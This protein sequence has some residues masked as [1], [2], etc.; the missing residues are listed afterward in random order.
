MIASLKSFC[1]VL[2]QHCS[3]SLPRVNKKINVTQSG[4]NWWKNVYSN[5]I[6]DFFAPFE[7][8][9]KGVWYNWNAF[10]FHPI[11]PFVLID[12]KC[13]RNNWA[14]KIDTNEIKLQLKH[15]AA[16]VDIIIIIINAG[17]IST[18]L[19]NLM[20][21]KLWRNRCWWEMCCAQP[22]GESKED[23]I[24]LES[25]NI[26]LLNAAMMWFMSSFSDLQMEK[27]HTRKVIWS[28]FPS[29]SKEERVGKTC[30]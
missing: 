13:D 7:V 17:R 26:F 16:C 21:K 4:A 20:K 2:P 9:W 12:F 8:N 11:F 28:E 19:A 24:K 15:Q 30:G 14:L 27:S 29:S 22:D 1:H 18:K 23:L 25:K 3:A 5:F 10:T 6:Y